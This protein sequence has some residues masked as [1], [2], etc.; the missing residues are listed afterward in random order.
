MLAYKASLSRDEDVATLVRANRLAAYLVF[1]RRLSNWCSSIGEIEMFDV[2][3]ECDEEVRRG[4]VQECT[5]EAV[6][7]KQALMCLVLTCERKAVREAELV[8]DIALA[9]AN[10]VVDGLWPSCHPGADRHAE[11]LPRAEDELVLVLADEIGIGVDELNSLEYGNGI[12]LGG[13]GKR[14]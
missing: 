3:E 8:Y 14:Y 2:A 5:T 7:V 13:S 12:I 9:W 6:E 4:L 11:D 1:K 10:D